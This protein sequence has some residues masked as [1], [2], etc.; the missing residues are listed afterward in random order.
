M[1]N[2]WTLALAAAGVVSLP[3]LR[4]EEQ[5]Q[6][7]TALSQTTLSGYVDTS[8]NVYAGRTGALPGRTFDGADKQDGFNL[9]KVQ[10]T[11]EKPLDEGQ[12]SAGYRTDLVFGPD[13]NYYG[14]VLNGVGA[15]AAP[16]DDFNI[17]Q[18]YVALRAPVG[19]GLDVKLGVFDTL[20]GYEVYETGN[21]PNYSRSYG[22]ALEPTHHTGVLLSYHVADWLSVSAGVANGWTGPINDKIQGGTGPRDWAD[23]K[24]F[25]GAVTITLPEGTGPVAGSAIYAGIV[26][27]ENTS[28]I[29]IPS[30]ARPFTPGGGDNPDTTSYYAGATLNTGLQ[31]LSV[32]AAFDYRHNGVTADPG[33]LVQTVDVKAW[34]IAGYA[35]YQATEKLK[36]NARYDYLHAND[37]TFFTSTSATHARNELG[38]LTFTADYSLWAN[39]ITRAE[40]RWDHA[41]NGDKPFGANKTT[42]VADDK[43][44]VTVAANLIYKF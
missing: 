38:A 4:A 7:L 18:A 5:H 24:A 36:L 33:L 14:T 31:G 1:I 3:S 27:G 13:A 17:K 25:L 35:S 42:G 32:G 23:R 30:A 41:F 20:I 22:Y 44:A 40:V 16:A 26:H 34:S 2:K 43:N 10:L 37:H 6:V 11:L 28:S 21:N 15:G 8:A 9:N 19:N 39:V 29:A 12:W